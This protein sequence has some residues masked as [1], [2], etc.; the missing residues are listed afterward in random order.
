MWTPG[1]T[2]I[3]KSPN[4]YPCVLRFLDVGISLRTDGDKV[5]TMGRR[6]SADRR[7]RMYTG[8]GRGEIVVWNA[9]GSYRATIGRRGNGPGEFASGALGI[10]G[11]PDK[12]LYVFDN[13]RRWSVLDSNYV[14]KRSVQWYGSLSP[15]RSAVLSDGGLLDAERPTDKKFSFSITRLRS[16]DGR[17][18][19]D[20]AMLLAVRTFGRIPNA[21]AK[22][23]QSARVR[24]ISY[25]GKDRFWAGPPQAAGRGYELQEWSVTGTL[26]RTL[27]RSVEW[28]PPQIDMLPTRVQ[29]ASR[30]PPGEIEMLHSLGGGLLWVV[31]RVTNDASWRAA[32]RAPKDTAL[33]GKSFNLYSE[34]ID[35]YSGTVLAS[36]GP[37][38]IADAQRNFPINWIEGTLRGSRMFEDSD[39][40]QVHRMVEARLYGR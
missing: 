30:P 31:I 38:S 24:L 12:E 4:R 6:V 11:S 27:R 2:L 18:R 36:I 34:V 25:T 20:T 29:E 19:P 15:T 7:G 17:T 26:I 22:L 16:L 3:L 13:N 37:L 33:L 23:P 1:E 21:E 32:L 8:T 10:H 28:Y 14:F 5:Q 40:E 35:T 9:D 39:G